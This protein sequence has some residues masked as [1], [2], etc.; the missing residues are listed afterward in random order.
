MTNVIPE[1]INPALRIK[2]DDPRAMGVLRSYIASN[3]NDAQ[4][5]NLLGW[6]LTERNQFRAA[7]SA[8]ARAA[9]HNEEKRIPLLCDLANCLRLEERFEESESLYNSLLGEAP[10]D[11]DLMYG[12]GLLRYDQGRFD[13][14]VALFDKSIA[15]QDPDKWGHHRWPYW[16]R[17]LSYLSM[18]QW[19]RGFAEYDVRFDVR[20]KGFTDV[21]LPM[22]QGEDLDGKTI[23]VLGEQGLGDVIMFG[24]YVP[25]LKAERVIFHVQR[26]L[27][28]FLQRQR[29]PGVIIE[30]IGAPMP[31]ADYYCPVG[32]LP[33]RLG[34]KTIDGT[35]YLKNVTEPPVSIPSSDGLKVGVCFATSRVQYRQQLRKLSP[36][37]LLEWADLPNISLYSLQV[38][39]G[40]E[41][42]VQSGVDSFVPNLGLYFQDIA[43]T[44]SIMDQLDLVISVDTGLAHLAGAMG[45]E[46]WTLLPFVSCWRWN[47]WSS[48]TPWYDSMR[49]VREKNPGDWED[50]VSRVANALVQKGYAKKNENLAESA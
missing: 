3:P 35:P 8:Y 33:N 31:M 44:A 47:R 17:T 5:L 48:R 12:F 30:P 7:R 22:W 49:L 39:E 14:A 24:R 28:R 2:S 46:C 38:G 26:E 36:D 29:W 10:D 50:V 13:E 1:D 20:L 15:K 32:S 41:A 6:F 23:F 42:L 9:Q 25:Q 40:Q 43:D 37:V 21:P 45:K 18:G 4:A 19:E 11:P 34:I 27:Y 16:D